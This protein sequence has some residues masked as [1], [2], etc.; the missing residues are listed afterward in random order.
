[1][2]AQPPPDPSLL[3]AKVCAAIHA[4]PDAFKD[5]LARWRS[6]YPMTAFPDPRKN[7]EVYEGIIGRERMRGPANFS[8][9]FA[10][11]VGGW[12][13]ADISY[14]KGDRL[15]EPSTNPKFNPEHFPSM[16]LRNMEKLLVK[17][18]FPDG[19]QTVDLTR[20]EE[21]EKMGI[22]RSYFTTSPSLN[23]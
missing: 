21:S 9:S 19:H 14:D 6:K 10:E 11:F 8:R 23:V 17:T 2:P 3:I 22:N 15:L 18:I 13:H 1:M 20:P 5:A 16:S 12:V 7:I 4:G